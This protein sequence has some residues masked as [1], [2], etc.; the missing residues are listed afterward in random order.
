MRDAI[1]TYGSSALPQF[2]GLTIFPRLPSGF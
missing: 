1:K 2:G